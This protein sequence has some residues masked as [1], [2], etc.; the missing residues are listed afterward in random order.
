MS[1]ATAPR[2]PRARAAAPSVRIE[3]ARTAWLEALAEGDAAFSERFGI[4]VAPGWVGF[5]EALPGAVEGAR[6]HDADPWGTH[7]IFDGADGALVGFGGFK[8]APAD[9][10]VEIGYAIA[11]ERRNRGLAGAAV[12]LMVERART[13]GV[14]VVVAH[15]LHEPNASTSVLTRCGFT[16]VA[17]V[18][19]PDDG[20]QVWRWELDLRR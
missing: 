8:G 20:G 15:T 4:P 16:R 19:D 1:W 14:Q 12:L 17:T 13:A 5:P 6:R 7:L 9:R 11:P 18:E 3:P 10:R 2:P